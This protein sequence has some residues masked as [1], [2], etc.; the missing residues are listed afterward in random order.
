MKC[1]QFTLLDEVKVFVP[2]YKIN[3]WVRLG[4][5]ERIECRRESRSALFQITAS[6]A[7]ERI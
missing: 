6:S 1:Q 5:S 2:V 7:M 3:P 4:H